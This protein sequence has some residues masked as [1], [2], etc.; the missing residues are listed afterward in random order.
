MKKLSLHIFLLL[1]WCNI[2]F[3][4]D[5]KEF[6]IDGIK[7]YDN[8]YDILTDEI[9]SEN[10]EKIKDSKLYGGNKEFP[11]L[12]INP[13]KIIDQSKVLNNY[14]F[15]KIHYKKKDNQIHLISGTTYF[16]DLDMRQCI[17]N[18]NSIKF[19]LDNIYNSPLNRNETGI[20]PHS[21]T[22]LIGAT[23]KSVS[24]TYPDFGIRI[25]C[26]DFTE[27]KNFSGPKNRSIRFELQGYT[28]ELSSWVNKN[29][30]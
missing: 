13:N 23:L 21:S 29:N 28:H 1:L 16:G 18:L 27:Y 9:I 19:R 25:I 4:N 15:I 5:I 30:N 22:R 3:S 14:D 10:I 2:G 7:I 24:Y 20:I 17:N 26:Y 6:E 8:I 11:W 12:L